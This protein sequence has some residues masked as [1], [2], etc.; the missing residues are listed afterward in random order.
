MVTAMTTEDPDSNEARLARH[1]DEN[2]TVHPDV[3][4]ARK[5]AAVKAVERVCECIEKY[6]RACVFIGV[7]SQVGND[8]AQATAAREAR[9]ARDAVYEALKEVIGPW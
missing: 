2:R 6:G 5:A 4:A 9:A 3:L 1:R 7:A 8:D